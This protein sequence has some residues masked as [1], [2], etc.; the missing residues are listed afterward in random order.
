MESKMVKDKQEIDQ[1]VRK[2]QDTWLEHRVDELES[3]YHENVV[4]FSPGN[5]KRTAGQQAMIE[6]YRKFLSSSTNHN[7]Q[8]M[9]LQIDVFGTTA[10][11]IVTFEISYQSQDKNYDEQDNDIMILNNA[12]ANWKIVWRTQIPVK[13]SGL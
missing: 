2:L 8:I 4:F 10:I 3:F 9:D 12:E 7:F 6:S 13:N 11:A 5:G 1:L